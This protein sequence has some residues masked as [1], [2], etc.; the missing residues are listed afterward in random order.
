MED[1]HLD[2]KKPYIC[3]GNKDGVL[4]FIQ[5]GIL[6]NMKGNKI[7]VMEH[8]EEIEMT[9]KSNNF[10]KCDICGKIYEN[11]KFLETHKKKFHK[12]KG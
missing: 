8:K 9:E 3:Q 6:Y 11:E 4:T 2:L 5:D 1:K 12:M 7:G 10:V